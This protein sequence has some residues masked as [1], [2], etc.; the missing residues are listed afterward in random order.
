M[1]CYVDCRPV[2]APRPGRAHGA[3]AGR[4]EARIFTYR[5]AQFRYKYISKNGLIARARGE[6]RASIEHE[7]TD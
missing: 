2:L 5:N 1:R 7:S 4:A 3:Q 6:A